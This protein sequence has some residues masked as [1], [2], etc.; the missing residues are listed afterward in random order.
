M[1]LSTS[2][3]QPKPRSPHEIAPNLGNSR[4]RASRGSIGALSGRSAVRLPPV[5]AA[6]L[7]PTGVPRTS[8]VR[9][10]ITSKHAHSRRPA[11]ACPT[12]YTGRRPSRGVQQPPPTAPT[13]RGV[14]RQQTYHDC[15]SVVKM[16]HEGFEPSSDR[17][18]SSGPCRRYRICPEGRTMLHFLYCIYEGLWNT[19]LGHRVVDWM[20]D[21][22]YYEP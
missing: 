2:A 5:F 8:S 21:I 9:E 18:S 22:N 16:E 15:G 1:P 19:R 10:R 11:T 3:P 12:K 20:I 17:C 14:E 13:W 6:G 4:V 7:A